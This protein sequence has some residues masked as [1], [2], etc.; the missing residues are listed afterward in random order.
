MN[1]LSDRGVFLFQGGYRGGSGRHM[2]RWSTASR[3]VLWWSLLVG[4]Q[5]E[6]CVE[7]V[8]GR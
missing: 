2:G 7:S 4:E 3:D 1:H 6:R 5:R 8:L